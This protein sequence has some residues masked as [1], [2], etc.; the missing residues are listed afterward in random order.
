[1]L[2]HPGTSHNDDIGAVFVSKR[3]PNRRHA[4]EGIGTSYDIG[5]GKA[6]GAVAGAT[7]MN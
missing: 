3:L 2:G 6:E 5:D 7:F 4:G 1:M